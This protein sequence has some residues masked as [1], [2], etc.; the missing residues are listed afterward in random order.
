MR[1]LGNLSGGLASLRDISIDISKDMSESELLLR[2]V[3]A[4]PRLPPSLV[5]LRTQQGFTP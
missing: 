1:P 2:D 3:K 4:S 5:Q